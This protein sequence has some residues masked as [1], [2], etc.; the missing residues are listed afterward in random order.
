M[1]Y[2]SV[3]MASRA[4]NTAL[5]IWFTILSVV[6]LYV[7]SLPGPWLSNE[8]GLFATIVDSPACGIYSEVM[9]EYNDGSTVGFE[10]TEE[11][12]RR[13]LERHD[14]IH[15]GLIKPDKLFERALRDRRPNHVGQ[16]HLAECVSTYERAVNESLAWRRS[17][18]LSGDEMKHTYERLKR[19][20][21][22]KK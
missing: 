4:G 3:V 17:V 1:D 18:G 14:W 7:A 20:R 10:N 22:L 19:K 16:M 12:G 21:S 8:H 9:V 2:P 15:C 13:H 6:F 5:A 11:C